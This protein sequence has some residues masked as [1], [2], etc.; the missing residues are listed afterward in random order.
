[1]NIDPLGY[2]ECQAKILARP[3]SKDCLSYVD[4]LIVSCR[5][6]KLDFRATGKQLST[7]QNLT[8]EFE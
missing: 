3:F 7:Y 6:V 8:L 5:D 2:F 4:K 1:M